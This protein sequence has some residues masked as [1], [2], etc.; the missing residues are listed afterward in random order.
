MKFLL[1]EWALTLIPQ[2]EL[3]AFHLRYLFL[4]ASFLLFLHWLRKVYNKCKNIISE[5]HL[6]TYPQ[7]CAQLSI[8]DISKLFCKNTVFFQHC[9]MDFFIW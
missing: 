2:M 1:L 8:H 9:Q 7:T 5:N 4:L 6:F 3:K